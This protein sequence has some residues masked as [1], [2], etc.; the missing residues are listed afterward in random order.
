MGRRQAKA[1]HRLLAAALGLTAYGQAT[2]IMGL[3]DVLDT[4]EGG[5]RDRHAGDYWVAVFGEPSEEGVWGWRLEGH[6]VSLNYTLAGHDVVGVPLFLG[7]NPA[8]L[9]RAGAAAVRP[10]GYEEDLAR[11]LLASR[12]RRQR[13]RAVIDDEAPA[14]IVSGTQP[15]LAG[16]L[17]PNG[18][19][20]AD[21]AGESSELLRQL[22]ITYSGRLPEDV[23]SAQLTRLDEAGLGEVHFAW[24]GEPEPGR[25]HYYRV[26]GPRLLVELD[27]T[28]DGANHVHT[29]MRDP[30][31]DF[32]H[33]LLLAH[34]Q[35]HHDDGDSAGP[36]TRD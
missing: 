15:R 11:A 30:E 14:D 35:A 20:G 17:E 2:T 13:Q 7:A 27:N 34:R 33:D 23:A 12:Q 32:G 22:V 10:L 1:A 5:S 9:P 16:E 24:A 31:D 29:V 25:P 6:H 8:A 3:E 26:Q 21:L 18:L 19:P 36:K 4:I 28:Q